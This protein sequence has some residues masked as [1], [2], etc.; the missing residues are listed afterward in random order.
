MSAG[1]GLSSE[2]IE[3]LADAEEN[4]LDYLYEEN[5]VVKLNTEAWKENA[6]AKMLGE[7]DEIKKRLIL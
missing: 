1:G 2:T 5:G 6:N 7:M 4:Y 3:K